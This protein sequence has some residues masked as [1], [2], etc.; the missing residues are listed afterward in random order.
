M[1]E[2][3]ARDALLEELKRLAEPDRR[4]LLDYARSLG[5]QAP[6]GVTGESLAA[7]VGSLPEAD[8]VSIAEAI[9]DGCEKVDLSAW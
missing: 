9:E 2:S 7:Y 1:R 6:K 5:T 4:R 8:A 3:S